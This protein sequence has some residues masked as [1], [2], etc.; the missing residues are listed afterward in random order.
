M[1]KKQIQVYRV[2]LADKS[3]MDMAINEMVR[4]GVNFEKINGR[5]PKKVKCVETGIIYESAK[6][7]SKSMGLNNKAVNHSIINR[8]RCGG[9]Y[10]VYA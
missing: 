7:A 2:K 8:R 4:M 5:K 3:Y 1:T 10:W 6:I 9:Y